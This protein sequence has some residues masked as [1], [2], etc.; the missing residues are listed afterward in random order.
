MKNGMWDGIMNCTGD[1]WDNGYGIVDIRC[2][3]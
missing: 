2:W 1:T 3:M